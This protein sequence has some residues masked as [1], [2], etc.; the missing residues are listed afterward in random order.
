MANEKEVAL[1][2]ISLAQKSLPIVNDINEGLSSQVDCEVV[3]SAH[4]LQNPGIGVFDESDVAEELQGAER[5]NAIFL[6]ECWRKNSFDIDNLTVAFLNRPFVFG[7]RISRREAGFHFFG[8][9][10]ITSDGSLVDGSYGTM[11]GNRDLPGDVLSKSEGGFKYQGPQFAE[12][13]SGTY[14]LIGNVHRHFGHVLLEGLTRLWALR[15]F[16]ADPSIRFAIYE[17]EVKPFALKLLELAGVDLARI[18]T[19]PKAAIVEKLIV[20]SPSMRSHRWITAQQMDVWQ[21]IAEKA[22]SASRTAPTRKVYLSRKR[23]PD[24][25]LDNELEVEHFFVKQGFEVICPETI[26]LHEQIKTARESCI[27][28]GPVGSQM[29]LAAFQQKN[30]ALFVVAPRNFYLRDDS[31]VASANNARLQ[32]CFGSSIDFKKP[33]EDRSWCID[34]EKL[35]RSYSIFENE[36]EV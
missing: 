2:S 21:T 4:A 24:R 27:L 33:K 6:P 31:L 25:P 29:Y 26:D 28:A 32:V 5:G 20:P 19:I 12:E 30:T 13:F 8:Q 36:I 7:G 15:H 14:Y 9:T 16:S 35:E 11:D 10:V 3:F 1:S 23:I 22:A 18:V 34:I 17:D